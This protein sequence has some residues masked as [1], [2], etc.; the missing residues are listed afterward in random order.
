MTNNQRPAAHLYSA[1]GVAAVLLPVLAGDGAAD[2]N[3]SGWVVDGGGAVMVAAVG[4]RADIKGAA[5]RVARLLGIRAVAFPWTHH[6]PQGQGAQTLI[7]GCPVRYIPARCILHTGKLCA[8][9]ARG[10][11]FGGIDVPIDSQLQGAAEGLT[12]L[13]ASWEG[14]AHASQHERVKGRSH[15]VREE[16][17]AR[18]KTQVKPPTPPAGRSCSHQALRLCL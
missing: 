14:T 6:P 15:T 17:V 9:A 5:L 10:V 13:V 1:A 8:G 18:L 11:G 2:D 3:G 7:Q 4:S 12:T 16:T